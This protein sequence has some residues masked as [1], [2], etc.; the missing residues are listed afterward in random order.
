MEA[1]QTAAGMTPSARP[2]IDCGDL[3]MRIAADGSW[4]YRRSRIDRPALVKLF[5]SVLRKEPD[6]SYWLVTP[7]E[8]GRVEV[9]DVPFV[10]VEAEVR[11]EGRERRIALRTNVERWVEVG[12]AHSLRAGTGPDGQGRVYVGLERGLEAVL[13]RPVWYELLEL[14][15]LDSESLAG[16]ELWAGG[17][18]FDLSGL[19]G[20][21]D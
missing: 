4:Y 15:I 17:V 3:D 8:R 1:K 20:A 6:G 9:D 10:A 21:A 12:A 13:A 14:A 11:G 19:A 2:R 5:A 18:R 7:V 16:V